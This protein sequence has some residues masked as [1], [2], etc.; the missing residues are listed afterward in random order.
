MKYF[1]TQ[2]GDFSEQVTEVTFSLHYSSC[3]R[4]RKRERGREKEL[5]SELASNFS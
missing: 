2:K 4:E 3:A 1:A 5:S